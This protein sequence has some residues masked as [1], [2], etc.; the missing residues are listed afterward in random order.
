[1]G[2]DAH[3]HCAVMPIL[4]AEAHLTTQNQITIPAPIRKALKL[5][6]GKSRVKFQIS[7]GG[8]VLVARV[9]PPA[10]ESEDPALKPFLDLLARDMQEHPERIRPFPVT[11]LTRARSATEG[12]EVDLDGPLTG[13]A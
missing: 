4:E 3:Y 13:D 12:V 1:M 6:G 11:L 5:T 8:K 2:M 10:E 9:E 7:N